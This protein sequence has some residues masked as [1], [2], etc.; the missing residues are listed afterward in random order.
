MMLKYLSERKK[1]K[2]ATINERCLTHI[3]IRFKMLSNK[4]NK[5]MPRPKGSPNK[6][7]AE[8]KDKL[9]EAADSI[10]VKEMNKSERLKLIQITIQYILPRL[11]QVEDDTEEQPREFQLE[12]INSL[13][14]NK[15]LKRII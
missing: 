12:I 4:Y 5:N 3:T 10:D 1:E 13:S 14:K 15:Y 2:I 6:I 9:C 7:T 11:K 8:I